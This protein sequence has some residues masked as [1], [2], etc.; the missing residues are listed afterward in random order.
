MPSIFSN[1]LSKTSHPSVKEL[2]MDDEEGLLHASPDT[3]RK[4]QLIL[5]MVVEDDNLSPG[6]MWCDEDDE[7]CV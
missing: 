6:E 1:Q 7:R 3:F 5:S 4:F 2:D